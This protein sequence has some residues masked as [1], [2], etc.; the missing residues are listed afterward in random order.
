MP[1]LQIHTVEQPE[2]EITAFILSCNRLDLLNQTIRSFLA[3]KEIPV[4]VVLV[5]DSGLPE[6][7]D[8]LV[9]AY[10]HFADI[11]CFP[12]NRGLWWAKDFMVSFCHTKYIFYVEED[13]LFLNSGYLQKSVKILE[14]HRDIGSIDLSWRTFEEEGFDSYDPELIEGE[15]YKKKPWQISPTHFHWFCWQGSPNLK[16]REDLLL[17]GRVEQFYTEWNIDRKFF[18]LG[19]RGVFLKTRYVAHL[20][21]HRSLMVNKRPNENATPETL[22]PQELLPNRIYPRFDYY[23]MDQ[24]A[25]KLRGNTDIYRH[26]TKTFVTCL[27]DINREQQDGR[28]F[29]QHYMGGL[30]KLIALKFPLVIFVDARHYY[31]V[32]SMTGGKPI[33]V[34]PVDPR[35]VELTEDFKRISEICNDPEWYGQSE[36]MQNSII[37]SPAYIG[38]TLHKMKFMMH[39]VNHNVFR[40]EAYYWIDSGMCRSFNIPDLAS[41]DFSRLPTDRFFMTTFPY[42]VETEMHGYSRKGFEGL[43]RQIPDFVCRAT[44]FGGTKQAIADINDKYNDFLQRSLSA[45]YIGTE[46]AIFSGLAVEEPQLFNLAVMSSGDINH[47]LDTLRG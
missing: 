29:L 19:L 47:Y 27:L 7:F 40:S 21:D 6:V 4:K 28:N 35:L 37:R 11:V 23:A 25:S 32:L 30:T 5:D 12:V 20:G 22:F 42:I 13:W 15:Y 17:L 41:Y 24:Y 3:T 26:N 45:G 1:K 31:A 33:Q 43:C 46:E 2:S 39:C 18:A 34:V 8:K 14:D 38:L 9:T 16:R 36:W 44:L 10:G